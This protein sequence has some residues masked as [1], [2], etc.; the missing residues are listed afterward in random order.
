MYFKSDIKQPEILN[1]RDICQNNFPK[2][3][4]LF[5]VISCF[6]KS[7]TSITARHELIGCVINE[8]F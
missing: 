1:D 2:L 8:M 4:L 7:C 3:K 5:Y 6:L